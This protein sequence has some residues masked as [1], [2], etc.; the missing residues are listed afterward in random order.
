[1]SANDEDI[2]RKWPQLTESEQNGFL[3]AMATA[4]I[5]TKRAQ[6][7]PAHIAVASHWTA[8][9]MIAKETLGHR[10]LLPH[11][12]WIAA[13]VGAVGIFFVGLH[14]AIAAVVAIV[15]LIVAAKVMTI[16][17]KSRVVS[18]ATV[19]PEAFD[20]LWDIGLIALKI[21]SSPNIFAK[22]GT[23]V[24]WQDIV[25]MELGWDECMQQVPLSRESAMKDILSRAMGS[26][27]L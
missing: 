16:L 9:S 12:L 7:W 1:M 26:R 13:V 10:F 3:H 20:K 24:R 6:I 2:R 17:T 22:P 4:L 27:T 21:S 25:L 19:S 18:A 14:W 8:G 11:L 23:G 5:E 15:L